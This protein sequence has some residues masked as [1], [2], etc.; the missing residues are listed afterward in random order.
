MGFP[1][2]G[3]GFGWMDG[4]LQCL[5]VFLFPSFSF[6]AGTA[7]R[8]DRVVLAFLY[9]FFLFCLFFLCLTPVGFI[10]ISSHFRYLPRQACF[11]AEDGQ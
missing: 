7:N 4:G 5:Q 11:L 1:F 9:F 10:S 3:W 2:S 8:F 6:S